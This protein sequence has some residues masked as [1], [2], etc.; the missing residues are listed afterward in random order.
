METGKKSDIDVMCSIKKTLDNFKGTRNEEFASIVS[1]VN[2]YILTQC[3]HEILTDCVDIYPT[4]SV[5]MHY[6]KHC[7]T[8]FPN[9]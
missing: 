5:F 8:T 4:N 1:S 3:A 2:N 7:F 6:C 9:N